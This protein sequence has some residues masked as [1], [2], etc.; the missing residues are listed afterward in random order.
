[1]I[2]CVKHMRA[3]CH[4]L[5]CVA[6]LLQVSQVWNLDT[7]LSVE[8]NSLTALKHIDMTRGAA[9]CLHLWISCT[10]MHHSLFYLLTPR[11]QE[12][13]ICSFCSSHHDHRGEGTSS[14]LLTPHI[15]S[16]KTWDVCLLAA[17]SRLLSS[18]AGCSG[19]SHGQNDHQA[20]HRRGR[21]GEQR[22]GGGEQAEGHLPGELQG[23][24]GWERY[25]KAQKHSRESVKRDIRTVQLREINRWWFLNYIIKIQLI[26]VIHCRRSV[27]I[28]VQFKQCQHDLLV[29]VDSII[30]HF[31]EHGETF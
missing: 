9:T 24:Y 6:K 16:S 1:M 18:S 30:I 15:T 8:I 5:V 20:D 25:Q 29:K 17:V 2:S 31:V 28:T 11:Y 7:S 23:L 22:P 27:V 4:F 21:R 12:G 3:W 26:C 10:E 13:S 14:D 19:V